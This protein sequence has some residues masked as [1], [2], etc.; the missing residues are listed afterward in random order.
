M[1]ALTSKTSTKELPLLR[2][3]APSGTRQAHES[4]PPLSTGP[5]ESPSNPTSQ[6]E[7]PGTI[8]GS[9]PKEPPFVTQMQ[10]PPELQQS[11]FTTSPNA[12]SAEFV[13]PMYTATNSEAFHCT[14]KCPSVLKHMVHSH[15]YNCRSY[16]RLVV[17]C[18]LSRRLL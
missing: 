1:H 14:D 7:M 12:E 18:D 6:N 4:G 5:T 9:C 16:T 8:P 3:G 2:Q 15:T 17:A 10:R 11:A 13:L